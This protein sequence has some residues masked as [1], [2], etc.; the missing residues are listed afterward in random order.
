LPIIRD[1][2]EGAKQLLPPDFESEAAEIS[3]ALDNWDPLCKAIGQW[4]SAGKTDKERIADVSAQGIVTT[5]K[6]LIDKASQSKLDEKKVRCLEGIARDT[7]VARSILQSAKQQVD[8]DCLESFNLAMQALGDIA[9]GV[10]GGSSWL[11]GLGEDSSLEDV[12]GVAKETILKL[13]GKKFDSTIDEVTSALDA[14]KVWLEVL[15]SDLSAE[16][17]T[18]ASDLLKEA[19]A[20]K[21]SA[22]LV[23]ASIEHKDAIPKL[24][25]MVRKHRASI[26]EHKCAANVNKALLEWSARVSSL[27]A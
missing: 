15:G 22:L 18:R 5:L 8:I 4:Q 23:H 21:Y 7:G 11:D 26:E 25:R 13:D 16:I 20:T 1:L 12:V 2:V 6:G 19:R 27:K 17:L 10:A 14:Y 3:Q 24:R 9:K